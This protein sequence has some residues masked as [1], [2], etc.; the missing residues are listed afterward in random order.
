MSLFNFLEGVIAGEE[1]HLLL[2]PLDG[3]EEL[4]DHEKDQDEAGQ[5]DSVDIALDADEFGQS[6]AEIW[7]EYNER[8]TTPND[9]A[10]AE[11][12]D[13][14]MVFTFQIIAHTLIEHERGEDENDDLIELK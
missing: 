12:Q 8:H 6:I 13:G 7:E 1:R 4:E 2:E 5:D 14:L 10:D 11:L 3:G 9:H